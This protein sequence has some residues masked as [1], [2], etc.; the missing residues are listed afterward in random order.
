MFYLLTD[1]E[2]KTWRDVL[3]GEN[4]THTETNTNYYFEVYK[5]PILAAYLAPRS[6][7]QFDKMAPKIWL[8]TGE[9]DTIDWG[10]TQQFEKLTTVKDIGFRFPSTE[11][12]RICAILAA[13]NLVAHP[14]FLEWANNYISG[15]DISLETA[16]KTYD[17][18]KTAM[19]S[20]D[21]VE[22]QMQ[23]ATAHGIFAGFVKN[24]PDFFNACSIYK[25][26]YDAIDRELSLKLEE[27]V[28]IA[29]EVPQEEIANILV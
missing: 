5:S 16:E 7:S 1:Q 14:A 11:N 10:M 19:N 13:M 17:E 12:R 18:I 24:N 3:W 9:G 6:L 21:T 4:V 23:F 25:A 20:V 8:A 29:Y 22:E 27:I 15:K 26:Y 28:K 2:N